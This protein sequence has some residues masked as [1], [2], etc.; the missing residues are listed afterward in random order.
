MDLH[1]RKGAIVCSGGSLHRT[2]SWPAAPW[3]PPA[4][5][6]RLW[7]HAVLWA[8]CPRSSGTHRR[9]QHAARPAN[10]ST[11]SVGTGVTDG[12]PPA[13]VRPDVASLP[14][15]SPRCPPHEY[16]S[17]SQ[18]FPRLCRRWLS[19]T[20]ARLSLALPLTKLRED[21]PHPPASRC[22]RSR[23]RGGDRAPGT[24]APEQ[25]PFQG[26]ESVQTAFEAVTHRHS[27]HADTP[28]ASG[29]CGG[30]LCPSNAP[31]EWQ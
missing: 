29:G 11:V 26:T 13:P 15:L 10:V 28:S 21:G 30:I 31:G 7:G 12:D 16:S 3:A 2:P 19:L 25:T 23:V 5:P 4:S 14:T 20:A 1:P 24:R 27:C 6:H 22:A 9:S 8:R 17:P 18:R